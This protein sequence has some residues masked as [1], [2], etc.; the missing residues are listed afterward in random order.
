M[1]VPDADENLTIVKINAKTHDLKTIFKNLNKKLNVN[2]HFGKKTLVK[3]YYAGHGVMR[4]LLHIVVSEKHRPYPIEK[5]L[6]TLAT[7]PDCAILAIF[8]CCRN[9]PSD[10]L[11]KHRGGEDKE[12]DNGL[13]LREGANNCIFY[14]STMPTETTP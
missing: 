4:D 5:M 3:F 1:K 12:E 9:K 6:L 13:E 7:V 10:A 2:S 14:F 8:D 11:F